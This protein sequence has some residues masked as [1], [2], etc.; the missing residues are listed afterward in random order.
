MSR[1]DKIFAVETLNLRVYTEID[2]G[3]VPVTESPEEVL[4][5]LGNPL[6]IDDEADFETGDIDS[7]TR[8][9]AVLGAHVPSEVEVAVVAEAVYGSVLLEDVVVTGDMAYIAIDELTEASVVGRLVAK[10]RLVCHGFGDSLD[11]VLG[12][13]HVVVQVVLGQKAVVVSIDDNVIYAEPVLGV[14]RCD[15]L[16]VH[17]VDDGFK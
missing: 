9:A 16:P 1:G 14:L 15:L 10:C 13:V 17:H 4:R 11:I 8:K 7:G 6:A 2:N 3:Q 12:A 5:A